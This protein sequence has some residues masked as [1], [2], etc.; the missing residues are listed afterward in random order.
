MLL[1][2][3][4]PGPG[5]EPRAAGL[6]LQHRGA[7]RLEEPAV[8]GDQHDRR[9]D[10][11]EALLEPFQR[12][13]VEVVGRLVQEQQVRVAGQR[14]RKRAAGQLSARER[15][16][17]AVEVVVVE[18]E[19]PDH[20]HRA[21]APVV[22]AG[23]LE[24]R[25][26]GRVGVERRLVGGALPHR[27]LQP[28]ELLLGGDQLAAPGQHVLAQRQVLVAR[29]ALVVQGDRGALLDRQLSLVD[30]RL[31]GQHP[32]QRGLARA[33]AA[34]QGQPVAPLDLERDVREQGLAGDRACARLDPMATAMGP[35]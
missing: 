29:R 30:R 13:D 26:C 4:V 3:R 20:R 2:P 22:A 21:L 9:V 8:V 28:R 7:D 1:A 32:Q 18:A 27:L 5:E 6:Q 14:A 19:M 15:A 10:R 16:Q 24:P 17:L 34:G 31:A 12:R 35:W 11:G 33:V 23:V 25:L